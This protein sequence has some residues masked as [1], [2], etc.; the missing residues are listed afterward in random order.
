M[1]KAFDGRERTWK[2]KKYE[3]L[4]YLGCKQSRQDSIPLSNVIYID[5]NPD[6]TIADDAPE[7][8][9]CVATM[10]QHGEHWKVDNIEIYNIY[11]NRDSGR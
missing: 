11:S 9:Q 10:E 8:L 7:L 5:D 3:L 6:F 1:P 2:K 4:A